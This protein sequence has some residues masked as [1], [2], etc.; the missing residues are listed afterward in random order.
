M[1]YLSKSLLSGYHD[2]DLNTLMI[3][4]IKNQI[5]LETEKEGHCHS[6][7]LVVDSM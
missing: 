3:G 1:P 2:G 5:N 6:L 7:F 4:G